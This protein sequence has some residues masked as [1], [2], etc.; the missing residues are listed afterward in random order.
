MARHLVLGDPVVSL[1]AETL[2]PDGGLVIEDATV[3]AAG[4]REA[5]AVLIDAH[6]QILSLAVD[7]EF[8]AAYGRE[9]SRPM[10]R[11]MHNDPSRP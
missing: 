7:P 11:K 4:P 2:V 1:G 3:V 9:G 6:S 10:L 5:A 8:P